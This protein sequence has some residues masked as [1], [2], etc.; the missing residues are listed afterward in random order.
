MLVFAMHT[1]WILLIHVYWLANTVGSCVELVLLL[2]ATDLL[3]TAG[4]LCKQIV[5]H[6]FWHMYTWTCLLWQMFI[7]Y[8]CTLF[9]PVTHIQTCIHMCGNA[10]VHTHLDTKT[11]THIG[12]N[13]RTGGW[14]LQSG[15]ISQLSVLTPRKRKKRS[16]A[17]TWISLFS[18]RI[19]RLPLFNLIYPIAFPTPMDSSFHTVCQWQLVIF[20]KSMQKHN[21]VSLML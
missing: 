2:T 15:T 20:A 18:D 14:P 5:T 4:R 12:R 8:I 19:F 13:M 3:T 1:Q 16:L 6:W 10:C 9:L 11:H 7:L 21:L 17:I